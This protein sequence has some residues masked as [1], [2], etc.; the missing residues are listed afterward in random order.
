[1]RSALVVSL[2]SLTTCLCI[3]SQGEACADT[4]SLVENRLVTDGQGYQQFVAQL[5]NKVPSQ[6]ANFHGELAR[7][8][9]DVMTRALAV[10]AQYDGAFESSVALFDVRA[11]H[12]WLTS[13]PIGLQPLAVQ[14][15]SRTFLPRPLSEVGQIINPEKGFYL[16]FRDA[17]TAADV[18]Q[19]KSIGIEILQ[20]I[21]GTTYFAKADRRSL[22]SI[23]GVTAVVGVANAFPEDRM[24]VNIA[25]HNFQAQRADGFIS[26]TISLGT[27]NT[28]AHFNSVSNAV[29]ALGGGVLSDAELLASE[30][31]IRADM[32][33]AK[34][35]ALLAQ[36]PEI[37]AVEESTI[38]LPVSC[39][40]ETN[41]LHGI[42]AIHALGYSGGQVAS[43]PGRAI[44]TGQLDEGGVLAAHNEFAGITMTGA[45]A[46]TVADHSTAMASI[47]L[48]IGANPTAVG[49]APTSLTHR[50][51]LNSNITN[52]FILAGQ[53]GVDVVNNSY[54]QNV[55]W[56]ASGTNWTN[57]TVNFGNYGTLT[58][59]IDTQG[60]NFPSM[61]IVYAATNQRTETGVGQPH[62]GTFEPNFVN[63]WT[64]AGIP[65]NHYSD[66]L[67]PY[68]IAKNSIVVG[69]VDDVGVMT[70]YSSWGPADDGR[71]K[72][73]VVAHGDNVTAAASTGVSNYLS[74]N[75]TS[76]S[77]AVATGLS[78][79]I[80]QAYLDRFSISDIS[81]ALMR[82]LIVQGADDMYVTNSYPGPDIM[83][84]YGLMNAGNS[85]SLITPTAPRTFEGT[86]VN[87]QALEIGV[88]EV[89]PNESLLSAT[90]AW[91]EGAGS[92][93]AVNVILNDL[94]LEFRTPD[95]L[96]VNSSAK[97]DPS[98]VINPAT[99]GKNSVDTTERAYFYSPAAGY[100]TVFVKGFSVAA[101]TQPYGLVNDRALSASYARF[102]A[103]LV[104]GQNTTLQVK[105]PPSQGVFVAFDLNPLLPAGIPVPGFTGNLWIGAPTILFTGATDVNG[106]VSFVLPIPAGTPAGLAVNFQVG[107]G[108]QILAPMQV[109]TQ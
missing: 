59:N 46:A 103:P 61:L 74:G 84:G 66:L 80:K 49:V 67:T 105:G 52:S 6:P 31:L 24:H 83:T 100:Y 64:G 29:L 43:V 95:G 86:V 63:V 94:D 37:G 36:V 33:P 23:D 7:D 82:A 96:L 77:T 47:I 42:N 40:L 91:T 76:A 25:K 16:Q 72:P 92:A 9:S 44:L 89:Q 18:T 54:G 56:D 21:T 27:F 90:L 50:V 22:A 98:A 13:L 14:L 99:Y 3:I 87:G 20:L 19:L 28:P 11:Q 106:D 97:L 65:N 30:G 107:V 32:L 102:T 108:T 109:V 57:N 5:N 26:I 55:G 101:A 104:G 60:K 45:T 8:F 68:N 75:G 71:I 38:A 1:M 78:A 17:V 62:D 2:I 15:K 12:A 35:S 70:D 58:I 88:L 73:D 79:L 53:A 51:A 48:G 85:I 4:L 81:S 41:T 10:R 39:D 93:T 69:A 34:I